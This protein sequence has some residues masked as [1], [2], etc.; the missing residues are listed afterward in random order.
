[1]PPPEQLRKR[2]ADLMGL[3]DGDLARLLSLGTE[4]LYDLL[5]ALIDQYGSA[6]S[7]LAAEWYDDA[8]AAAEVRGRFAA[9]PADLPDTS[10]SL[11][12]WAQSTATTPEA[13]ASLLAGG[14]Q[15]RIASY[16][17]HT[18]MDSS[19][20]DPRAE[21]WMR[22][23]RVSGCGFCRMLAGRGAVYNE[24]SVRF[25][26]HDGCHCQAAPKWSGKADLFDVAEYRRSTRARSDSITEAD[27]ARARD[28]IAAN[29]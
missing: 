16:A 11:I 13:F 5:P 10:G 2:L 14:A 20:A 1:M 8:R 12:G 17:R 22:V 7:L 27:N 9:I 25:G 18:V 23:A 19:V 24:S 3:A 4:A 15:R 29:L 26:A 21:G 6:A 28:W